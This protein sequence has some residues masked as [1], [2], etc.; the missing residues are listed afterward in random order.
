MIILK[1]ARGGKKHLIYRGEKVRITFT[2]ETYL[3]IF[4]SW[5]IGISHTALWFHVREFDNYCEI[6]IPPCLANI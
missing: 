4:H 2:N 1:E 6:R 5:T 3:T